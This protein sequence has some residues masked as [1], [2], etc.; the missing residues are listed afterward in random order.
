MNSGPGEPGGGD[1][2]RLEKKVSIG[3]LFTGV[4]L[5]VGVSFF[6]ATFNQRMESIEEKQSDNKAFIERSAVRNE[7]VSIR[8]TKME[9][10][11]TN[12][13]KLVALQS[14]VLNRIDR[15]LPEDDAGQRP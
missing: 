5:L 7:E 2:W 8:M 15:K 11:L 12:L 9:I 1:V 6:I 10:E 4:T 3:E 14:S 13:Q